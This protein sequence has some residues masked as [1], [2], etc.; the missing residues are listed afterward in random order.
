MSGWEKNEKKKAI[1]RLPRSGI[2]IESEITHASKTSA[3]D[4]ACG[5]LKSAISGRLGYWA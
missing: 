5:K 2:E 3:F 1:F 4:G